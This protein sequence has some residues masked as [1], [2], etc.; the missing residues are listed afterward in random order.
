MT[1]GTKLQCYRVRRTEDGASKSRRVSEKVKGKSLQVLKKESCKF[2][3]LK[4]TVIKINKIRSYFVDFLQ[5]I[6]DLK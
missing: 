3:C 2:G 5:V 1:P 4:V 6:I